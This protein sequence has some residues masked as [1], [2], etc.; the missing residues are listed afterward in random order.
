MVTVNHSDWVNTCR[1]RCRYLSVP[2]LISETERELARPSLESLLCTLNPWV[3]C[4]MISIFLTFQSSGSGETTAL[5]VFVNR[6][7]WCFLTLLNCPSICFSL[8]S[9]SVNSL[10]WHFTSDN[11]LNY[12]TSG[13]QN[14]INKI[15]TKRKNTLQKFL[16]F[17]YQQG[18]LLD[19]ATRMLWKKPPTNY[20]LVFSGLKQVI[21]SHS[22]AGQ[23]GWLCF[24]LILFP[25]PVN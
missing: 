23:L 19:I 4:N 14:L 12:C 15:S 24:I 1:Y 20:P 16:Q 2:L 25:G 18:N 6:P 3:P 22:S 10:F 21:C 17:A 11:F 5:L 7:Q 8:I 9:H 13:I